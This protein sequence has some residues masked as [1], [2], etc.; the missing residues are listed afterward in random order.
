MSTSQLSTQSAEERRSAEAQLSGLIAKFAPAHERLVGAVRRSL[1]KRLPTAHELVY[2]YRDCFVISCSPNEH[3]YE[4]V[5]AIRAS[6]NGV[7][8]Y[9]NFGKGLPDPEKLLQGSGGQTRWI[10]LEGAS[11]LARPAVARLIDE[12]IAR[13][14]VPFAPTGRG[15]VVMRSVEAKPRPRRRPD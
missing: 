12:A 7:R 13:N 10:P 9:F 3:G 11:T 8:L 2:E 14:R 1:R 6:A 15:P 5:F 4:G